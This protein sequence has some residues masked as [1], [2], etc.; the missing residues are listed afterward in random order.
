MKKTLVSLSIIGRCLFVAGLLLSLPLHA[1]AQMPQLTDSLQCCDLLFV[2][3]FKGNAITDVTMGF[4]NTPIDHVAIYYNI[5][6]ER[7][8]VEAWPDGGVQTGSLAHFL[9]RNKDNA[10][11]VGRLTTPFNKT[12]SLRNAFRYVG[13]PYDY[14]FLHDNDAIYCSELVQ[15]SFVDEHGQQLFS[16]IPMSFHDDSGQ[17]TAYWKAYYGSRNMAV[18]EGQPGTNPGELSRRPNIAI[19]FRLF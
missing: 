3:P 13:R 14:L 18:P 1:N 9:N 19:V 7:K 15:F 5:G 4:E 6:E 8:V 2:S 16:P 11:Y 17:I 12:Q 10:V